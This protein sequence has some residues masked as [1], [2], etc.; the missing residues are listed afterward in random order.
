MCVA[1]KMTI[2]AKNPFAASRYRISCGKCEECAAVYK[3]SWNFRLTA[4][5]EALMNNG[6][7]AGFITLTYNES[8][9][10]IVSPR[11]LLDNDSGKP[12]NEVW[13]Q[14]KDE[15]RFRGSVPRIPCF[16]RH[17]V[18]DYFVKIRQWL[19]R[20]YDLS[21]ENRLRYIAC[22]EFGS[23]TQRPHLHALVIFPKFVDARKLFEYMCDEWD[24]NGFTIPSKDHFEGWVDRKGKAH[25]GFVVDSY[26]SAARY[27][28]KYT[29]KDIYFSEAIDNALSRYRLSF[30]DDKKYLHHSLAFHVQ[31]KSLGLGIMQRFK[32]DADKLKAL[33]EGVFFVGEDKP[34]V[35]PIYIKNRILYDNEYQFEM[36]SPDSQKDSKFPVKY[37]L[38]CVAFGEDFP[39]K[40]IV[41][42]VASDFFKRNIEEIYK[43]KV[44]KYSEFFAQFADAGCM[45]TRRLAMCGRANIHV[46][47]YDFMG[48][49][50]KDL[51]SFM[52]DNGLVASD[53]AAL[54]LNYY[55]V[56]ENKR[57]FVPPSLYPLVYLQRYQDTPID[58]V[59]RVFDDGYNV[60]CNDLFGL[61]DNC[62]RWW[63]YVPKKRS[64]EERLADSLADMSKS[65]V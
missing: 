21:K 1:L 10:P 8:M 31:S 49:P 58:F 39:A 60:F 9:L 52:N 65:E 44:Q 56:P 42:R 57:I 23:D 36:V 13:N 24:F 59:G 61:L 40:R 35:L 50:F 41:K 34:R 30:A 12:L 15:P 7:Q 53:V 48:E 32:T 3:E 17:Q 47:A 18:T 25:K 2:K 16:E 26:A 43:L 20:N 55:G 5:L 46:S 4:E 27:T 22:C 64:Y 63:S 38:G 6:W 54:Y 28:A 62:F 11:K 37:E 29:T 33:K 51:R 14:V 45:H 19:F